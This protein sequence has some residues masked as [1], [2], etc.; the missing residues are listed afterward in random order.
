MKKLAKEFR[1]AWLPERVFMISIGTQIVDNFSG[2]CK[3]FSLVQDVKM[4]MKI[5]RQ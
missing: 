2:F 5:T 4:S 3:Y 1:L